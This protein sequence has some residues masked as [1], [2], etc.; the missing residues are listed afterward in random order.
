M[1]RPMKVWLRD[2]LPV[3]ITIQGITYEVGPD[4]NGNTIQQKNLEARRFDT[5]KSIKLAILPNIWYRDEYDRHAWFESWPKTP[6]RKLA[7]ALILQN[8][9][10]R[11]PNIE[12]IYLYKTDVCWEHI[13]NGCEFHDGISWQRKSFEN[14]SSLKPIHYLIR[15]KKSEI[16]NVSPSFTPT[17]CIRQKHP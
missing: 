17:N 7:N 1:T 2:A 13:P 6:A 3:H 16:K 4:G 15:F 14:S 8:L 5:G 10:V 11:K 9:A 12:W